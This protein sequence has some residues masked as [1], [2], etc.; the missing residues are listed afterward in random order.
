MHRDDWSSVFTN[1]DRI[2]EQLKPLENE[3]FLAG[4]TGL[5][6]I[7]LPFTYRHSEDLDFFFSTLKTN[8]E[9]ETIKNK[10]VELITNLDGAKLEIH[11]FQKVLQEVF[12]K[13]DT[14]DFNFLSKIQKKHQSI[15]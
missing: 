3:M 2:L 11:L 1:Q 12:E 10:I 15:T 14:L 7:V 9:L 8:K 4:G 5:Q 13:N 6:R